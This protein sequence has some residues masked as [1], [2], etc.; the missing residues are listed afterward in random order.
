MDNEL[1]IKYAWNK[2]NSGMITKE[3]LNLKLDV[4]NPTHRIGYS[5]DD[6]NFK[7]PLTIEFIAGDEYYMKPEKGKTKIMKYN[8]I[9][10]K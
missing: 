7:T 5:R 8:E 10:W 2:F 9:Y 3:E 6:V 4:L 1:L